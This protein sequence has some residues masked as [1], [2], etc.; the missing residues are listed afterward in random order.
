MGTP[1]PFVIF[2][3]RSALFVGPERKLVWSSNSVNTI[4]EIINFFLRFETKA[5]PE[6]LIST[7]QYLYTYQGSDDLYIRIPP[8]SIPSPTQIQAG[9]VQ[10]KDSTFYCIIHAPSLGW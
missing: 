5:K 4:Y 6:E 10:D 3:K 1:I 8:V 2:I 9:L 7:H